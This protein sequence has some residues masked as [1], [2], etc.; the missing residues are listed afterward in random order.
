MADLNAVPSRPPADDALRAELVRLVSLLDSPLALVDAANV[1][2]AWNE[3]AERL[4]GVAAPEVTDLPVELALGRLRLPHQPRGSLRLIADTSDEHPSQDPGFRPLC[5]DCYG[6][7]YP[8][9]PFTVIEIRRGQAEGDL[10]GDPLPLPHRL[11]QLRQFLSSDAGEP[12]PGRM[13]GHPVLAVPLRPGVP[14]NMVAELQ[15][16]EE[17]ELFARYYRSAPLLLVPRERGQVLVQ[18]IARVAATDVP[19]A[20]VGEGG[21]GKRL[22]AQ[23]VHLWS[24]RAAQPF[25]IVYG[26]ETFLSEAEADLARDDVPGQ[27]ADLWTALHDCRRGTVVL[28]RVEQMPERWLSWLMRAYEEAHW[29]SARAA[30]GF[31]NVRLIITRTLSLP[32]QSTGHRQFVSTMSIAQ[33]DVPRLRAWPELIEPL[34]WYFVTR[35]NQKY[36]T[37][38]CRI[39]PAVL[40]L[41]RDCQWPGN[42]RQ[43]RSVVFQACAQ[44][45]RGT[46][47]EETVLPVLQNAQRAGEDEERS[48]LIAALRAADNNRRRAA[49]LLGISTSTLYRKLK[50]LGLV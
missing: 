24:L 14:P 28:H 10:A 31:P 40:R 35:F 17:L 23:L 46:L 9:G 44:A 37:D 22:V 45:V 36:R 42:A 39:E 15:T 30:G 21:T 12:R 6:I 43:L 4:T 7:G 33:V 48:R 19:L 32:A 25:R 41:L 3:A 8:V 16:V 34:T 47:T 20:V 50:R 5:T 18:R 11:D 27:E 1:V 49:R 2:L 13:L 29:G 38:I 26:P